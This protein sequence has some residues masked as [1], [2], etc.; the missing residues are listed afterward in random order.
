MLPKSSG[1]ETSL[2]H[3]V[4]NPFQDRDK[5][6]DHLKKC[7]EHNSSLTGPNSCS[8]FTCSFCPKIFSLKGNLVRHMKMCQ[9]NPNRDHVEFQC[10]SCSVVF[11]RSDNLESHKKV[12]GNYK[13]K[14][15]TCLY[16]DCHFS[17]S[18]KTALIEHLQGKHDAGIKPP[19]EFKFSCVSEFDTW[20]DEEEERTLSYY[21]LSTGV[22][23]SRSYYYCQHDG[24][25]L[26]H[27][28]KGEE[29]A[30]LQEKTG[31]DRL[32]QERS[33]CLKLLF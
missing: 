20:K 7:S 29:D 11:H 32:S 3:H 18:T 14:T 13:K 30:L 1:S 6:V 22:K 9:G 16:E 26:P 19:K 10:A 31:L 4:R 27:R 21:S 28:K 25:D 15:V 33:A 8:D 12:C 5:L 24:G 23:G 2:F 17:S